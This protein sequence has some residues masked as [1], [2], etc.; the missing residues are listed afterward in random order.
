[1]E[2]FPLQK[3]ID[4]HKG[5]ALA[6]EAQK[7]LAELEEAAEKLGALEAGGVDNW[8]GYSFAME[9]FWEGRA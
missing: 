8:E 7:Q 9:S 4:L 2:P 3:L 1:M 5:E 6:E